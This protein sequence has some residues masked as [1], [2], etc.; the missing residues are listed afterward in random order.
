VSVSRLSVLQEG[1]AGRGQRWQT[2]TMKAG[3]GTTLALDL[4]SGSLVD[5][6]LH[7]GRVTT[8]TGCLLRLVWQAGWT[9]AGGR[10]E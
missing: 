10:D 8:C 4:W 6:K 2:L 5:W 3:A 7:E 1:A 9:N